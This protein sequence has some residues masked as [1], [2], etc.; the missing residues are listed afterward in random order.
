MC[1]KIGQFSKMKALP[2]LQSETSNHDVSTCQI[3]ISIVFLVM[4][5]HHSVSKADSVAL[6]QDQSETVSFLKGVVSATPLLLFTS[7]DAIN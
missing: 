7:G 1:G 4:T 2:R 3:S 6:K 5:S